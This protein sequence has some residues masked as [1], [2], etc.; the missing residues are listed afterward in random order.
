MAAINLASVSVQRRARESLTG[1]EKI[2]G[3]RLI[4]KNP[5]NPQANISEEMPCGLCDSVFSDDNPPKSTHCG[6]IYHLDCIDNYCQQKIS[7]F[8]QEHQETIKNI[9][10]PSCKSDIL[11]QHVPPPL[12]CDD[13]NF[14]L[15]A[16]DHINRFA[17]DFFS[18]LKVF[19]QKA[20]TWIKSLDEIKELPVYI[21]IAAIITLPFPVFS[22]ILTCAGSCLLLTSRILVI[23][24]LSPKKARIDM[25][26]SPQM[27]LTTLLAALSVQNVFQIFTRTRAHFSPLFG[28]F[29]ATYSALYVYEGFIND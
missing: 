20:L 21:T 6:H 3:D 27:L 18:S 13:Q 29:L 23:N 7:E 4:W 5:K 15:K 17:K 24:D 1:C 12:N 2:E 22:S 10:C 9:E 11:V 19:S 14:F 25:Y 16:L 8:F 28:F 26:K